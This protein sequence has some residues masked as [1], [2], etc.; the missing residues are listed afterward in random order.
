MKKQEKQVYED[1]LELYSGC[2]AMCGSS[3]YVECHHIRYGA[4]GRKT[5]MGNVIPLCEEHHKLV[6]TNKKKYQPILIDM[7]N[8]K[9]ETEVC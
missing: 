8:K 9:L 3:A 7:I 4:C 6:H 5:Y 1:T 2:C